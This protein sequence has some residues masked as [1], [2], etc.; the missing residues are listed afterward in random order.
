MITSNV[1]SDVE[2]KTGVKLPKSSRF[3][4]VGNDPR[5]DSEV[6]L[7]EIESNNT[8]QFPRQLDPQSIANGRDVEQMME[9]VGAISIGTPKTLYFGTWEMSN[10]QCQATLITA[11]N[12]D[13]L[14]LEKLY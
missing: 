1:I 14:M 8:A 9:Q 4:F 12:C 7:F 2:I 6:W 5:L 11:S 3:V 13:Y 10:A